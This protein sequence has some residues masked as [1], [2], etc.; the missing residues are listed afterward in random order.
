MIKKPRLLPVFL[1]NSG[2]LVNELYYGPYS[3]FWWDFSTENN[4]ANFPIRLNQQVKVFLN[5][6]DFFLTVKK[7]AGNLPEYHCKRGVNHE[8]VQYSSQSHRFFF[9]GWALKENEK[10]KSRE[11]AKRMTAEVKRLLEIMF[12][13]GMANPRQK[14]NAQ[15]MHE[16]LLQRVHQGELCEEDVPK[17]STI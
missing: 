11:P 15:Q 13:T 2:L 3:R 4:V 16:E 9:S 10:T 1:E 12:H 5:G 7:G 17:I 8:P 6:N 14:M